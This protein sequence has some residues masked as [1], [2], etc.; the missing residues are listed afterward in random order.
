MLVV[1]ALPAAVAGC[2]H[3]P[4]AETEF[5]CPARGG[6]AWVEVRSGHF[7]LHGDVTP[8]EG[9]A[10]VLDLEQMREALIGGLFPGQSMEIDRVVQ[11][12]AFRRAVDYAEFAPPHVMAYLSQDGLGE[13]VIV[14]PAEPERVHG[15]PDEAGPGAS[16]GD[17]QQPRGVSAWFR[18]L[19]GE[20][21]PGETRPGARLVIVHELTHH[22]LRYAYPRQPR[23]FGEGMAALSEILASERSSFGRVPTHVA[24]GYQRHP[25]PMR[26][27]LAWDGRSNDLS[28][29]DS[30]AMLVHYLLD[31]EEHRFDDFRRRLAGAERPDA[32]FATVFPEWAPATRD[33]P[34]ALD[35][36]VAEHA[37]RPAGKEWPARGATHERPDV[38]E[39]SASEV[40]AIRLALN[41]FQATAEAARLQREEMQEA[42]AEDPGHV[43]ALQ[44]KA[45]I[46]SLDPLPLAERAAAAHPDDL[47]ATLWLAQSLPR[48]T[49]EAEDRRLAALRHAVDIAPWSAM[50]ANNLAWNLLQRGNREEALPLAEQAARLSPGDPMILDT[51]ARALEAAGRCPEALRAAERAL[52]FLPEH[53][54]EGALAPWLE[55]AD[56]LR[57]TCGPGATSASHP[58]TSPGLPAGLRS[59]RPVPDGRLV[60]QPARFRSSRRRA[61]PA[62][63]A[64]PPSRRRRG[65]RA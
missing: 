59:G 20:S 57:A 29:H 51:L 23:W 8:G 22:L 19:M 10:L 18:S 49:E 37:Q 14:M 35:L 50:A 12:V 25:V 9:R 33:G 64:G 28:E 62:P 31:E 34:E 30:A 36:L 17:R 16:G 24:R 54:P 5:R 27:L 48:G 47:R 45:A 41:R 56:R 61:R 58:S 43:L 46:Y 15:M 11:V 4:W 63:P 3:T 44:V 40:H 39:L 42:L 2:A 26:Q 13:H 53:A 38:R 55:R 7:R 6:P 65:P 21:S 60:R 1:L 52:D 32:A